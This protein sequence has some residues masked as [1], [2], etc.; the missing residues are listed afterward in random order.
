MAKQSELSINCLQLLGEPFRGSASASN[1]FES[2]R[3][4]PASVEI[5]KVLPN[6]NRFTVTKLEIAQKHLS[7]AIILSQNTGSDFIRE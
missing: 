3:G 1:V 6:R 2:G 4:T 7:F 5:N